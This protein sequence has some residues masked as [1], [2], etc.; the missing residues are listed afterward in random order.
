MKNLVVIIVT[1]SFWACSCDRNIP[2]IAFKFEKICVDTIFFKG[3]PN[4]VTRFKLFVNSKKDILEVSEANQGNTTLYCPLT[5]N[6]LKDEVKINDTSITTPSLFSETDFYKKNSFFC[7]NEYHYEIRLM[8]IESKNN[9]TTIRDMKD[10][11]M[12][13]ILKP[14]EC[15]NCNF[16]IRFFAFNNSYHSEPFCIPVDSIVK[17]LRNN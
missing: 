4:Q 15:L 13:K 1:L 14:H 5:G 16:V 8:I 9:S 2:P 11:E 6:D 12:L 3:T 10:A 7:N 17:N